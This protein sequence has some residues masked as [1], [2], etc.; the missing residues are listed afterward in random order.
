MLLQEATVAT[1]ERLGKQL[2]IHADDGRVLCLH[3]GMSGQVQLVDP[4]DPVK[5]HT[6]CT[7][8]LREGRRRLEMRF[9]DPRRF[10]GLW[11]FASRDRLLGDRWSQLG[12]DALDLDPGLLARQLEG[13]ARGLKATLLDQAIVAGLGNIYVDEI[14][15]RARLHPR[16]PAGTVK[17]D[18]VERIADATLGILGQAIQQG[19]STVR[20]WLDSEGQVGEFARSH[21]VYGRS[22][23]MCVDCGQPLRDDLVAQRQTVWCPN[24]QRLKRRKR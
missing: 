1:L 9:V 23:D 13:R 5:P 8:S 15:F 6:H 21:K 18:E 2:A 3:L 10:G 7:W 12:P 14:L 16:Q 22:G 11:T 4:G 17:R 24:C 20:S 19:G